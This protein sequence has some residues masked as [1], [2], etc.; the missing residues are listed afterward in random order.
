M[1][2]TCALLLLLLTINVS[3]SYCQLRDVSQSEFLKN[4]PAGVKEYYRAFDSLA[5]PTWK[6]SVYKNWSLN[7]L[8]KY[9]S[10]IYDANEYDPITKHK[11]DILRAKAARDAHTGWVGDASVIQEV[12]KRVSEKHAALILNPSWLTIVADTTESIPSIISNNPI[13]RWTEKKVRGK[14]TQI[15]KGSQFSVGDIIT[16]F[17]MKEW[18]YSRGLQKGN[19]YIVALYPIL[20]DTSGEVKYAIGGF[21]HVQRSIFP[22]ENGCVIDEDNLFQFFRCNKNTT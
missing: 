14:I 5:H 18:G 1:R 7:E 3:A 6:G 8:K 11:Y 21:S 4:A 17:Y 19:S 2:K 15:W 12:Q 13:L 9:S 20:Q 16:M 10:V 22:I